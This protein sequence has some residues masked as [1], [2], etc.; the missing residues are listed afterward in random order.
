MSSLLKGAILLKVISRSCVIERG[1]PLG[2]RRV[3]VEATTANKALLLIEHNTALGV[4]LA[5]T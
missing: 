5:L 3:P 2:A 1:H 4:Q